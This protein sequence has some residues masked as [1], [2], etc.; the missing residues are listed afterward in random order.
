[1]ENYA[2]FWLRVVAYIIDA[3]IVGIVGFVIGMIF[4]VGAVSTG[5]DISDP[6][7]GGNA[8]LQMISI[9]IGV[10]YFAGMESSSWQATVGK[11]ALGLV[12]TDLNGQR[13]SLGR[14]IGRYFGKILSALILLI[15]FIM[16]AFTE[17][18]Q[19]LHDMIAGT[20]VLKGQPGM[21]AT[22]PNVFN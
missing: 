4:G 7:G 11:K 8:V 16:V 10:A 1:M 2:G 5:T 17:R 9:A 12:V 19:G 15:G 14:A 3:I 18:K 20:L 13:I 21:V 6:T 22:D